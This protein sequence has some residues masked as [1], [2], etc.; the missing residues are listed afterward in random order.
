[1][2]AYPIIVVEKRSVGFDYFHHRQR[3]FA[4]HCVNEGRR[5]TDDLPLRRGHRVSQS[6]K[7]FETIPSI[8]TSPARRVPTIVVFIS[9][10]VV[11]EKGEKNVAVSYFIANTIKY[12]LRLASDVAECIPFTGDVR[13]TS[14]LRAFL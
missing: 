4:V 11:I 13:V 3:R 6:Q 10:V 9:I 14:V 7:G 2:E 5:G 8:S 12:V 1:M